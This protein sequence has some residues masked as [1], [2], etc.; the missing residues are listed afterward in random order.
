MGLGKN[1]TKA[2]TPFEL[3]SAW[4]QRLISVIIYSATIQHFVNR[5]TSHNNEQF[6]KPLPCVVSE[7]T[8]PVRVANSDSLGL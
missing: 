3:I 4:P 8:L 7:R 6:S 1:A 5:K 2:D